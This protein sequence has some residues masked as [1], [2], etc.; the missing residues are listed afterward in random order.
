MLI[1]SL[2]PTLDTMLMERQTSAKEKWFALCCVSIRNTTLIQGMKVD[3]GI[4]EEL[5]G[6]DQMAWVGA[7]N[8]IRACAEEIVYAELVYA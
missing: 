1:S 3:Q 4:T 8:N 5:K 6:R 7:M 2:P